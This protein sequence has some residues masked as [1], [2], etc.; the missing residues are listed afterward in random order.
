MFSSRIFL[1]F[2][3]Y[4]RTRHTKRHIFPILAL[5]SGYYGNRRLSKV[6]NVP[7]FC[8]LWF[9]IIELSNFHEFEVT[10]W[11]GKSN[12]RWFVHR[13]NLLITNN[14]LIKQLI[15]WNS[16]WNPQKQFN[17]TNWT[18]NRLI[19]MSR[20]PES[21]SILNFSRWIFFNF[22]RLTQV[23]RVFK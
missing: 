5:Y 17:Q 2:A 12:L 23:R 1:Y 22:L 16:P 6:G 21:C 11:I 8:W 15:L 18:I 3:V 7:G 19:S 9:T 4:P 13:L 10:I 20:T 14:S